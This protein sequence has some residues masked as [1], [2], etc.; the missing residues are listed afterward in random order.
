MTN[1]DKIFKAYDIRGIYPKEINEEVG[2]KI[3]WATAKFLKAKEIVVGQ[4]NR[5]SSKNLFKVLCEGIRDQ[6]VNVIEI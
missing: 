4:D 2:Y 6:G 1:L 5:P 3:G